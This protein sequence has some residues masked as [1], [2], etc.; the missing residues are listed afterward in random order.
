MHALLDEQPALDGRAKRHAKRRTFPCTAQFNAM[1]VLLK[2]WWFWLGAVGLIVAALIAV[3]FVASTS[4]SSDERRFQEIA[5]LLGRDGIC[6]EPRMSRS[7]W[8]L[9]VKATPSS[10]QPWLVNSVSVQAVPD[11]RTLWERIQDEYRYQRRKHGW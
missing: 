7:K 6:T 2:R 1:P 4:R 10:S 8:L 11:N 9:V 3:L 5:D